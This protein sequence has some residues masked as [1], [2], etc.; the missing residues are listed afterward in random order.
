MFEGY[1][2]DKSNDRIWVIPEMTKEEITGKSEKELN[3]LLSG[4][5]HGEGFNFDTKNINEETVSS[6]Q[7]GQKVIVTFDNYL[8]LF[9]GRFEKDNVLVILY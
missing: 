4:K 7:V 8:Y 6:L 2:V 3:A 9:L 5:Y 1:I